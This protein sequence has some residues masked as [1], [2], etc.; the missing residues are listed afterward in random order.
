VKVSV[1]R[2]GGLAGITTRTE[3]SRSALP[4]A[5]AGILDRL[6]EEAGVREPPAP[7]SP[8][9][10]DQMLYEV[11]ISDDDG[12]VRVRFTD[13]DLPDGVRKLIEWVD[14]RAE[15]IHRLDV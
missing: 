6:V 8:S 2:G 4:T 5:A 10:P 14:S 3:V 11:E 12:T 9:G 7:S 1:V 13:A 15:K